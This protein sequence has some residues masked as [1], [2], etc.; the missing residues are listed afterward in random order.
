MSLCQ[1]VNEIVS[2]SLV[3]G[4]GFIVVY[5]GV[6]GVGFGIMVVNLS[7]YKCGWDDCWVEFS[8]WVECGQVIKEELFLLV[9][10]DIQVFEVVLIVFCLLKGSDEE[11]VVCQ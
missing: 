8:E 1:F 5:L 11:K 10:Q 2:E 3:L 6:L 7:S 9:D 4:G